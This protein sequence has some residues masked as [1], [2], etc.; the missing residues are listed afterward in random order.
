MRNKN[1]GKVT[2]Y[3]PAL[4][5][6]V[7]FLTLVFAGQVRAVEMTLDDALDIALNRT[8]RGGIIKGNMEVAEQQ[9]DAKKINFY[10]PKI[11]I[12]GSIPS[13]SSVVQTKNRCLKLGI[14]IS[15][16]SLNWNR[17]F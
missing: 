2:F 16:L 8:P 3:Q 6:F 10:L 15:I 9:Y 11:S 12:N 13:Y 7:F 1:I 17:A 4:I 5:F 14:L